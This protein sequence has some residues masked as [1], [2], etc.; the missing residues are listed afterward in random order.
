MFLS[1]EDRSSRLLILFFGIICILLLMT[2]ILIILYKTE[3]STL[4]CDQA[5]T[6]RKQ[7]KNSH[8]VCFSS[9]L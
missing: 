4:K 8:A 1:N 3:R 9:P 2:I 7:I 5:E 6:S